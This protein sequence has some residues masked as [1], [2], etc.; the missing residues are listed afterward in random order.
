[1]LPTSRSLYKHS[2]SDEL[3]RVTIPS[4]AA[5]PEALFHDVEFRV[6]YA[7]TDQM[8]VV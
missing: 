6:R 8:G 4:S 3:H 7:E 5:P 2:T 1:M